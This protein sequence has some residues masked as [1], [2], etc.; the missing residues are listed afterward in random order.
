MMKWIIMLYILLI[1]YLLQVQ[2]LN[3]SCKDTIYS[4][5]HTPILNWIIHYNSYLVYNQY[6]KLKLNLL[7]QYLRKSNL[8]FKEIL[9][10][11]LN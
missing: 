3:H 4:K 9:A 8:I 1:V 10:K 11:T 6:K 7:I 5:I 2:Y